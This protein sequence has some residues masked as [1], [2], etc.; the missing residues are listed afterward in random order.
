M[1]ILIIEDEDIIRDGISEFLIDNGYDVWTSSD[2]KEGL[3]K[4]YEQE[5]HLIILDII[6]PQMNGT[7]VVQEI[8]KSSQIPIIMLTALSDEKTQAQCFDIQAA[9]YISKPFSLLILLKRIE[10][11]IRRHYPAQNIWTYKEAKVDFTAWTA[12]YQG[13][14]ALVK[15]KEIKLLAILLQHKGQTL[16][17]EQ[18]LNLIWQDEEAPYDRVIDVYIKNL[19]KKLHLDCINTIKGVG[20]KIVI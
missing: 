7:D 3:S 11:L 15:P 8:R 9:D 17:R 6:M 5:F 13:K 18:I 12:T 19:R 4:F 16:S 10:A 1:N 14:D 20:Y 2:G